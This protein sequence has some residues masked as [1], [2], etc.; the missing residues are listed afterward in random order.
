MPAGGCEGST[1]SS[2]SGDEDKQFK[3][4]EAEIKSL[5]AQ[6]ERFRGQRGEAGQ[7]GPSDSVRKE[8]VVEKRL[9]AERSW[10]TRGKGYRDSCDRSKN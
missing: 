8:S 10:T 1:G 4:Q 3:S 5:R 9:R 7:D 6:V 2:S